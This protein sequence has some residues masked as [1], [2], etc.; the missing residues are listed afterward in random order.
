MKT[1][2]WKRRNRHTRPEWVNAYRFIK[3]EGWYFPM[4]VYLTL[5]DG[6]FHVSDNLGHRWTTLFPT[7]TFSQGSEKGWMP[8]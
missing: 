8:F 2:R 7:N 6:R 3:L 5:C 4:G 1:K